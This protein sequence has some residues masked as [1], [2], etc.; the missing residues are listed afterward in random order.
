MTY[1]EGFILAVPTANKEAFRKHAADAAPLFR[2]FGVT[3]HV[4]TW[5]DD[6]PDGK[7][8]DFRKAVQAKDDEAVAFSWFE[9]PDRATRDAANAKMMSDPR[10][11]EMGKDMPFDGK[12][13]IIG[14]FDTFVDE[15][16]SPGGYTDGFVLPVPERNRKAYHDM[17]D[18]AAAIFKDHGA[19]R[20]VEAWG[21][22]VPEVKVTDFRRSVKA[23]EGE[24]VVFSWIEW[25]SKEARDEG[26]KKV[27]ADE[28][29]TH[30]PNDNPFDGKRMFWGGFRPIL[31]TA[32]A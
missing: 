31:D 24:N 4:E 28:R 7:V 13:M 6:L 30:D 23:E 9:Y 12:R 17:A 10:M 14:G 15:G 5:G 8:T 11:E 18:K 22:D 27:M 21:D 20:V 16:G 1:V 26:W 25:P 3:R 29:M 19:V 32:K 2:E